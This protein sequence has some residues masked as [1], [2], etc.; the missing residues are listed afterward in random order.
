[1]RSNYTGYIF[2]YIIASSPFRRGAGVNQIVPGEFVVGVDIGVE[3]FVAVG[4]YVGVEVF[5][6][7][8]VYVGV[9]VFVAVGVDVGVGVLVTVAGSDGCVKLS[10]PGHTLRISKPQATIEL[11]IPIMLTTPPA[12]VT[13]PFGPSHFINCNASS[14]VTGGGSCG[15]SIGFVISCTT[16]LTAF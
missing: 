16:F 8:G 5:V 4:V 6:A 11:R 9:D 1:M 2:P 14:P 15:V 7:V 12:H 10:G 3:V 13:L